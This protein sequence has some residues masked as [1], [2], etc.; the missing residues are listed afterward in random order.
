MNWAHPLLTPTLSSATRGSTARGVCARPAHLLLRSSR[1]MMMKGSKL[2]PASHNP[3]QGPQHKGRRVLA[4]GSRFAG[5]FPDQHGHQK[6]GNSFCECVVINAGA[7]NQTVQNPPSFLQSSRYYFSSNFMLTAWLDSRPS[8]W[9]TTEGLEKP[10][11][12]PLCSLWSPF[13]SRRKCKCCIY[14]PNTCQE[15]KTH[16]R[17]FQTISNTDQDFIFF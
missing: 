9:L 1:G 11:L 17:N 10:S 14:K 12:N 13:L 16:Y 7:V 4:K 15:H 8:N 6:S 3:Q 5:I 2:P